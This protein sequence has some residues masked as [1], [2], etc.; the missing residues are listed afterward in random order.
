MIHSDDIIFDKEKAQQK[1]TIHKT[2]HRK[3]KLTEEQEVNTTKVTFVCKT[4]L[5]VIQPKNSNT[6][7]YLD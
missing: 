2:N 7:Y 5:Q 1:E 4:I 6:G 3:R